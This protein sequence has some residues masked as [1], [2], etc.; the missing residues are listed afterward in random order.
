M[1]VVVIDPAAPALPLPWP[2]ALP[3]AAL[4]PPACVPVL[5]L[6]LALTLIAPPAWTLPPALLLALAEADTVVL[7][8]ELTFDPDAVA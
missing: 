5:A 6:A 8:L 4:S 7:P 2:L 1:P 3:F